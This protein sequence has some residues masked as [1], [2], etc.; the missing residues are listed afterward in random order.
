MTEVSDDLGVLRSSIGGPVFGPDDTGYDEARSIWNGDIDHR[1][2]GIARCL[3]PGDVGSALGFARDRELEVSVRG[4]GH[5]FSGTAVSEGGLMIDL[6][7]MNGTSVESETAMARVGGGATM[8]DL[9]AATQAHGLAVTGGVISH[10]GVGGLTLGGGMG[11]LTHL[12]GLSIDNLASAEVVLADGSVVRASD[13]EHPDLFWAIRGGGGNFGVVTEFEYRLHPVGPEV[14]LGLFF[15]SLDD[16]ADALRL[17][18]EFIPTLPTRSG[19][20]IAA[21]MCAP[22][23]PF[24][25]EQ[26]RGVPGHALIVAG[27]SSAAEHA[28]AV[29]PIRDAVPPLFE[30]VTPIPYAGLQQMLDGAAPWGILGYEKAL[31]L[32]DLTDEVI[33]VLVEHAPR[34][35]SPL[36]FM[37]IFRLDGAF[38]SVGE[39]DTAFGGARTPHYVCNIAGVADTPELL[40]ADRA[41]T[42][43][44][45]EALRPL[46]SNQ[47]GYVN[48]MAEPDEN[49]VRASYGPT[50]YDRLA[51]V[52]AHYDPGNTFHLNA[53]IRPA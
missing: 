11:W 9:D 27:F 41:W 30:F 34:K 44:I 28:A 29:A 20:L 18:R 16:G 45:W 39:N 31:D 21:G 32:V 7:A 12:A 24:V 51:A 23:E 3:S 50:K 4:G 36:S 15:W 43:S 22:P 47:G 10:T 8:A 14:N 17:C 49:R 38:A 33:A 48:F 46:A 19:S 40:A 1:P 42:R 35:S 13:D 5:A 2:A 52:K 37:P 6:S 53:N 25:P 26:Y